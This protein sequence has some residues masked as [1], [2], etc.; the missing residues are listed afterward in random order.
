[1]NPARQTEEEWV[2]AYARSAGMTPDEIRTHMFEHRDQAVP[3]PCDCGEDY[4]T[5]WVWEPK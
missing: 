3:M 5:G 4:C 1:M 2:A